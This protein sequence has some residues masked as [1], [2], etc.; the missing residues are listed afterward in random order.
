MRAIYSDDA[1]TWR[2]KGRAESQ[3][4]LS[5][6]FRDIYYV[7]LRYLNLIDSNEPV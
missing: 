3:V 6:S 7:T 1:P 2:R 5:S 4:I